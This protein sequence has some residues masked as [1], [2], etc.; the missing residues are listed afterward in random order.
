MAGNANSGGRNAKP[1]SVHQAQGT[2]QPVRHDGFETPDPPRGRPA[3]PKS[4]AGEAKAEWDRMV[5]RLEHTKAL[6][7]VDDAALYQYVQLFAETERVTE[8]H[9]R[10][11]ALSNKLMKSVKPLHGPDL[12]EA[13]K[14]IVSMEFILAKQT[15]QL[16]QGHMGLR[17]WLIEFGMTPSART[18][19]KLP[20]D[21]TQPASDDDRF[22]GGPKGVV[23]GGKA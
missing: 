22:F 18:R 19:V 12:V 14:A 20:K 21:G 8:D 9:A 5:D 17:M 3:A 1:P 16:R 15:T 2:Y 23:R 7:R 11:R 13:V 10:I 4:L 6:T